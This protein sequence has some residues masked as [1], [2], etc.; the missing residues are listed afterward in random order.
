LPQVRRGVARPTFDPAKGRLWA[1]C[2]SSRRWNVTPLEERW[3]ALE[4]CGP[5]I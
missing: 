4:E 3:E 5:R 2:P 1:V